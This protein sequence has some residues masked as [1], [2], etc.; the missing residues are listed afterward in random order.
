MSPDCHGLKDPQKSPGMSRR[1]TISTTRVVTPRRFGHDRLLFL[2]C[3]RDPSAKSGQ[4][5][6]PWSKN[7]AFCRDPQFHHF[8]DQELCLQP[9]WCRKSEEGILDKTNKSSCS[10]VVFLKVALPS[11]WKVYLPR[12]FLAGCHCFDFTVAGYLVI[13]RDL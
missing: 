6:V 5:R 3:H 4:R 8:G 1:P 2:I 10:E 7:L 13:Q 11:C 9:N 12:L